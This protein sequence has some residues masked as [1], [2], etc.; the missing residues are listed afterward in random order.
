MKKQLRIIVLVLLLIVLLFTLAAVALGGYGSVLAV[1][2]ISVASALGAGYVWGF[3]VSPGNEEAMLRVGIITFFLVGVVVGTLNHYL[4]TCPNCGEKYA[5]FDSCYHCLEADP[6]C[7]ECGS[8][9][10]STFCGDC[11]TRMVK[12]G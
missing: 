7:S 3:I 12:A 10:D 2:G 9:W 11:G 4:P 1:I 6:I 8:E 5:Y